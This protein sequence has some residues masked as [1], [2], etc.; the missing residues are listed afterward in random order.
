MARLTGEEATKDEVA[1]A[2]AR[3]AAE[4]ERPIMMAMAEFWVAVAFF[5]FLV[6]LVYYKCPA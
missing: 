4:K 3:R 1:K 5:V 6:I 2:L